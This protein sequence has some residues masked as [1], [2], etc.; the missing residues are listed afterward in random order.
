MPRFAG[1]ADTLLE[2]CWPTLCRL[3]MHNRIFTVQPSYL[4]GESLVDLL[5]QQHIVAAGNMVNL[6]KTIYRIK[7][8]ATISLVGAITHG[9]QAPM[10]RNG[11][12]ALQYRK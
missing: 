4:A 8:I 1:P 6:C 11:R 10:N 2:K 7:S 5:Q 12:H 3:S 9:M